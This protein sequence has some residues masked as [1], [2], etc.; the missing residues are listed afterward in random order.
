[1]PTPVYRY[2][3]FLLL[4]LTGPL[5]ANEQAM[6]DLE[7]RNRL[8]VILAA[9][10]G[11]RNPQLDWSS[12]QA[13]YQSNEYFP[14]WLDYLGPTPH[15]VGLRQVLLDAG[16]EG[17]KVEKY[18]PEAIAGL[19]RSREPAEQVELELFLTDALFRYLQHVQ[20]GYRQPQLGEY[21]LDISPAQVDPVARLHQL[22]KADDFQAA[23]HKLGPQHPGYRRLRAALQRYRDIEQQGGWSVLPDGPSLK[24][25]SRHPQVGVLRQRLMAEGD[26]ELGP[27]HHPHYFDQAIKFAVER[28]QVRYGLKMDGVVGP[29]TRA[30]MNVPLAQRIEQITLNMERWRWLPRQLGQRY[31][32][33]NTAGF[34]L[35]AVKHDVIQ[36]TMSVII[37]TPKRPTPIVKGQF[38]T[39]VFNP[40][41][42]VP[43][44][45]IF[46][47]LV[48]RQLRDPRYLQAKGIRVLTNHREAS[49]VDP[50]SIDW[51]Q[52]DEN[53]FPYILRQDPGD[54]NPL[55]RIKFLFSNNHNVYLHDTPDRYLFDND[56][57]AYSSGCIRVA[58]PVQLGAF[59]LAGQDGW[60]E[61]R[62]RAAIDKGEHQRVAVPGTVPV[63]LVYMTSWVG[64]NN[65]VHFRPD[66]YHWDPKTQNCDAVR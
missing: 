10:T 42:T 38:H 27:V 14:V 25:D 4:L 45:I 9:S 56:S 35:A 36:F 64:A 60:N 31:V 43:Q 61:A 52:V 23:L 24:L 33:V 46:E 12:L 30:A 15:A 63:Y 19:W 34:Q 50:A 41:W 57:R 40:Y 66:I 5:W 54:S 28:F 3:C 13:F 65:G 39:V 37:G 55:G 20:N 2:C 17:L 7:L 47:D 29:K 22:L 18:H 32:I 49:E 6:R 16:Q 26:L 8:H 21:Y 44:T 62:I 58:D 1:L 51:S 53:H 59:L 48:P 11:P